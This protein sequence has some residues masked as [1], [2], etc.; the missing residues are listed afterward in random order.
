MANSSCCPEACKK[1]I[2]DKAAQIREKL[3]E[4]NGL[5][6]AYQEWIKILMYYG[7]DYQEDY[8][9]EQVNLE[10]A[11]NSEEA[12]EA[13]DE[14]DALTTQY[15]DHSEFVRDQLRALEPKIEAANIQL[16]EL[17]EQNKA[18]L[19]RCRDCF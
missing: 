7:E 12:Q 16:R 19:E 14:M 13:I 9:E 1:E 4:V 17:F 10:N 5:R 15:Q 6:D 11:S 18:I 2:N 8:M 3:D